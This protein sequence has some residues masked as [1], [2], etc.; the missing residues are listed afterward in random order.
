MDFADELI[1]AAR[2]VDLVVAAVC[3]LVVG[4]I[5]E[6]IEAARGVDFVVAAVYDLVVGF[7]S[8]LAESRKAYRSCRCHSEVKVSRVNI[9]LTSV[10]HAEVKNEKCDYSPRLSEY[11]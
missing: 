4:F 3:N 2:S 6:L 11:E 5:S 7:D 1:K 8:G 10:S 9:D